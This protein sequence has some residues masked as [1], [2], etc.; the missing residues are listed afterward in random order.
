MKL[1]FMNRTIDYLIKTIGREKTIQKIN[2]RFV[3]KDDKVTET[4]LIK[5]V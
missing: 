3:T 2:N 1:V 5:H 4:H